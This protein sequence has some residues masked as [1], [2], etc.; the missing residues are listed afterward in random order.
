MD[1]SRD[2]DT[3]AARGAAV[4]VVSEVIVVDLSNAVLDCLVSRSATI[5]IPDLLASIQRLRWRLAL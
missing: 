5:I 1:S 4:S 3:P 2:G